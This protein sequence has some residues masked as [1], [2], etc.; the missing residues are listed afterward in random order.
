MS[1]YYQNSKK[2]KVKFSLKPVIII[3]DN[4]EDRKGPWEI[5]ARDRERF[6]RRIQDIEN[7]IGWCFH[8]L[9]RE[10]ISCILNN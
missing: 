8:R 4:N 3:I 7:K 10:K 5:F 6:N 2:I 1:L 9:H